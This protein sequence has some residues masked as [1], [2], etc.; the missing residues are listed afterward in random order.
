[1]IKQINISKFVLKILLI[2]IL[3]VSCK[4]EALPDIDTKNTKPLSEIK[5]IISSD[6]G[7]AQIKAKA[8]SNTQIRLKY[9]G[10]LGSVITK[11]YQNNAGVFE[12]NI[13]LL[14]DFDQNIE[15][16]ATRNNKEYSYDLKSIPGY[17]Y[18]LNRDISTIKKQ[19]IN[20]KWKSNQLKSRIIT[21]QSN[22]SPPYNIFVTIAQKTFDFNENDN[23]IFKV[24]SPLKF[25]HKTGTW[26]INTDHIININTKIPLGPMEIK[27][28]KIHL[29][30][31]DNLS[32]LV[33][34]SDGVFLIYFDKEK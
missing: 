5:V 3:A 19:L 14:P 28:G 8:L 25:T 12:F 21:K 6:I 29:L 34:I 15:I 1:M 26:N 23:F 10:K 30:D 7:K 2:T 27:N 33:N 20:T 17:A 24:S 18:Q 13:D 16:I 22:P 4:K 31:D 32:L 11:I 9:K